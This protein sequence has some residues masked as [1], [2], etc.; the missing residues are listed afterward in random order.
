MTKEIYMV[1]KTY[2][3]VMNEITQIN[4]QENRKQEEKNDNDAILEKTDGL[5]GL[6]NNHIKIFLNTKSK[7]PPQFCS[8][9]YA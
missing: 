7:F 2:K 5:L 1:Q 3:E 9:V 4:Q 8:S 6:L